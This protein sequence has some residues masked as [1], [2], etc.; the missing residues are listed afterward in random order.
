MAD[1]VPALPQGPSKVREL[2]LSAKDTFLAATA[3]SLKW[4]AEANFA[5]QVLS[6]SEYAMK[7][8]LTNRQSV[9]NAVNNVAAIGLTLNPAMR[10]A[11][12]VPRDG[13]ICLDISYLGLIELA[14]QAGSIRWAQARSVCEKD[15]F[16]IGRVAEE[17]IHRFN[18]FG[19]R[20]RRIGAYVVAKTPQGDYLTH[21]ATMDEIHANRDRSSGWK[22]WIK[23]KKKSP[24]NTD[25]V[26][27]E[28]KTVV[29]AASKFWPKSERVAEAIHYLNTQGGEGFDPSLPQ[30]QEVETE[31]ADKHVQAVLAAKTRGEAMSAFK[32][33]QQALRNDPAAYERL[34]IATNKRLAEMRGGE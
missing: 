28:L 16:S 30:A 27:M 5:I 1:Q 12:L 26:A 6:A 20:G 21:W 10:L 19:A 33:G 22:A 29:K 34:R 18:A 31:V 25:P 15:E 8:A 7:T 11:Y 32:E 2:V 17:P 4:E 9:I 14:V 3:G 23:E 13:K 24:W